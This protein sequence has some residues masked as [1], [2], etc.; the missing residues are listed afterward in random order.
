MVAEHCET[1]SQSYFLVTDVGLENISIISSTPRNI[2]KVHCKSHKNLSLASKN[3]LF[4][5]QLVIYSQRLRIERLLFKIFGDSRLYL[6]FKVTM[7]NMWKFV[8][9]KISYFS[10]GT[11][12][13]GHN[14]HC[15]LGSSCLTFILIGTIT[16][17]LVV[18]RVVFILSY[19]LFRHCK[20]LLDLI[21]EYGTSRCHCLAI[22]LNAYTDKPQAHLVPFAHT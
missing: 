2:S 14:K 13:V 18:S 1:K 8:D 19:A 3:V 11:I 20:F 4:L 6:F 9:I 21:M 17:V 10:P 12:L 22:V 7:I 16:I 15:I 5:I